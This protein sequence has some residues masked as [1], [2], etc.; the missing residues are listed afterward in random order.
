MSYTDPDRDRQI[1][2]LRR[3]LADEQARYRETHALWSAGLRLAKARGD[4][5]MEAALSGYQD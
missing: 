2:D 1:A 3:Q 4:F 5:E